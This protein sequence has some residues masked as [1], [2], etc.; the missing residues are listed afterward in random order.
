MGSQKFALRRCQDAHPFC[1]EEHFLELPIYAMD[2]NVRHL[3]SVGDILHHTLRDVL[4]ACPT[5]LHTHGDTRVGAVYGVLD[6]LL[7]GGL[8]RL[9]DRET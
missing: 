7:D 6:A 8:H 3:P 1:D 4:A 2:S 9:M 5:L